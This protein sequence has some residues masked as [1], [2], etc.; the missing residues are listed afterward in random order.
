MSALTVGTASARPGARVNGAFPWIPLPTGQP[1]DLPVAILQGVSG[2]PC[3]WLTATL[4]GDEL[5][6]FHAIHSLLDTLSPEDLRGTIVAMPLLNPTGFRHQHRETDYD[7]ADPN[8]IFPSRRFSQRSASSSSIDV[9]E[10]L[11]GNASA[12]E[13]HFARLFDT[14]CESADCLLDL[15]CAFSQS[16]PFIFRDRV[17]YRDED[18]DERRELDERLSALVEALGLPVLNEL[19]ARRYLERNL[20]RSLTGAVLNEEGILSATI[21][22]GPKAIYHHDMIAVGL[23]ALRNAL[24]HLGMIEGQAATLS[25]LP[26]PPAGQAL[27]QHDGPRSPVSGILQYLVRPGDW[28]PAG[29]PVAHVVDV[30]GCAV[31]NSA[32]C[33]QGPCWIAGLANG[34]LAVPGAP[35]ALVG[36]PDRHHTLAV[37]PRWR[38]RQ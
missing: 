25:D 32:L 27:R 31:E 36:I 26:H 33:L 8:R 34:C 22:L 12:M 37:H 10:D 35:V 24:C 11:C 15:H 13:R 23:R 2:G 29:E 28:V 3:L 5:T 16:I 7:G 19:P 38:V 20:H 6:G 9:G 17:I 21:E 1:D 30:Q 14:I 18:Y 4:H